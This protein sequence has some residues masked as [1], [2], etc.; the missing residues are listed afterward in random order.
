M[1]FIFFSSFTSGVAISVFIT[2]ISWY[3]ENIFD[4]SMYLSYVLVS[5]YIFSFFAL[6]YISR[7]SDKYRSRL[8]LIGIYTLGTLVCLFLITYRDIKSL[9]VFYH[10]TLLVLATAILTM[11]KTAD[12]VVRSIYVK[13]KFRDGVIHKANKGLEV[14]R[15]G[16]TVFSGGFAYIF[17]R[18]DSLVY[19]CSFGL[20]CFIASIMISF[21][22]ENEKPVPPPQHR[23]KLE[24]AYTSGFQC[25]DNNK[26]ITL[27]IA[28]YVLVVSLNVLYPPLFNSFNALSS[29]FGIMVIPYGLGAIVGS[30]TSPQSIED[31]KKHYI[32]FSSLIVLSMLLPY[33]NAGIYS[34]YVMLFILALSHSYI[35]VM[36]NT[37]I[38]NYTS[39]G[40]ISN[41]MAYNE[42]LFIFFSVFST[43]FLA[44]LS[45]WLGIE[46]AWFFAL[47]MFLIVTI[48]VLRSPFLK[49]QGVFVQIP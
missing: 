38:M 3:V 18:D 34:L 28:P 33:L 15:Q 30:L 29:D 31:F 13:R 47:T 22:I 41:A 17:I 32:C 10:L 42:G 7:L 45:D 40:R 19:V 26:I 43:I 1:F 14:V 49:E 20:I 5:G 12:Q 21:W 9:P 4:S 48:L 16:I 35:R 2:A 44:F 37:L 46:L 6:P 36:R 8:V 23:N 24:H 11:V 25:G 27:T 39:K